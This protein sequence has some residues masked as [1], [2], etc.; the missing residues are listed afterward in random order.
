[1]RDQ[2]LGDRA[3]RAGLAAE[4]R[5]GIGPVAAPARVEQDRVTGLRID[6]AEAVDGDRAAG[7]EPLDAP[8]RCRVDQPPA[9]ENLRDRL[10]P[11]AGDARG[12]GPPGAAP[13]GAAPDPPL[14]G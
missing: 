12:A 14:C 7:L 6:V 11:E 10:D 2:P 8:R 1:M 5:V 4:V 13:A 9:R 3:A